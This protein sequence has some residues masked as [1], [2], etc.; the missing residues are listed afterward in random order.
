VVTF[1]HLPTLVALVAV[2]SMTGCSAVGMGI[3]TAIGAAS[4]RYTEL[5]PNDP[6]LTVGT[7]VRV[8]TIERHFGG[9]DE[10]AYEGT[11]AGT[12]DGALIVSSDDGEDAIKLAAVG[13]LSVRNG[14]NWWKG[15]A[16]G[17]IVGGIADV[18]FLIVGIATIHSAG[19]R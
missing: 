4:P 1:R 15:M 11:Y 17:L 19:P 14:T 7:K 8:R 9:K 2:P 6:L 12:R 3:G 18:A 5:S 13:E 16:T 10:D